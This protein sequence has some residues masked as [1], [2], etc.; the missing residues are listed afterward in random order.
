AQV[1]GAAK[2]AVDAVPPRR[3]FDLVQVLAPE[4]L[5]RGDLVAEALDAVCEP[6]RQARRTES[7]VA[8]AS[9]P[10]DSAGVEY[11]H[12]TPRR[13]LLRDERGPEPGEPGADD[14]EIGGCRAVE[15]IERRRRVEPIE[16]VR[17]RL[18]IGER[19]GDPVV[20]HQSGLSGRL[21]R[22]P[23]GN[24]HVAPRDQEAG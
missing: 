4:L 8:S 6:V 23:A 1:A 16:P 11:N 22:A 12:V 10:T 24:Q 21:P 18:G 3:G 5:Q 13:A 14:R 19:P 2:V 7:S 17:P 20:D 15:R 9:G